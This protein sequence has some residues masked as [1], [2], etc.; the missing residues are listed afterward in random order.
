M[1]VSELDPREVER[2]LLD[3]IRRNPSMQEIAALKHTDVQSPNEAIQALQDGN[4]RF[5]P[6]GHAA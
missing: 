3:A 6:I 2:R 5:F 4:A 1:R